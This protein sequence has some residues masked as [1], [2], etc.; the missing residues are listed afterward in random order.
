[1]GQS[2]VALVEFGVER[3]HVRH[4]R[5]GEVFDQLLQGEINLEKAGVGK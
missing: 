4:V 1:V 5:D 2:E 3:G